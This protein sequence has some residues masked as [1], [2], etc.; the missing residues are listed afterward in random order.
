MAY[1]KE[2]Y[3]KVF[4]K[5]AMQPGYSP[6]QQARDEA[7]RELREREAIKFMASNKEVSD[8]MNQLTPA[9]ERELRE[10]IMKYRSFIE[11]RLDTG[12]DYTY[13]FES[14]RKIV[15]RTKKHHNQACTCTDC[16]STKRRPAQARSARVSTGTFPNREHFGIIRKPSQARAIGTSVGEGLANGLSRVCGLL[17]QAFAPV[18]EWLKVK[19]T[20]EQADSKEA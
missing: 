8:I 19:E 9:E 17:K 15:M 13:N 3:E 10:H 14:G 4:G 18:H 11:E 1:T 7:L 16:T 2:S 20:D 5:G 12:W 6:Q